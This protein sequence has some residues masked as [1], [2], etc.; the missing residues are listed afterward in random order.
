MQVL[1]SKISKV[2]TLRGWEKFLLPHAERE[3][4]LIDLVYRLAVWV[5]SS[6]LDVANK[7]V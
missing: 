7:G 2:S 5:E 1:F 3:Y 6:N 4:Q